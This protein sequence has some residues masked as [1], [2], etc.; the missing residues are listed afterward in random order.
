MIIW[1]TGQPG[2]GKTTLAKEFISI[3]DHQKLIHIDGDDLRDLMDNKDYSYLG[4]VS[5]IKLAQNLALFMESKGFTPVVSLVS[6]YKVQRE[7]FKSKTTVLEVYLHTDEIRG[8]ENYFVDH[9]IEPNENYLD[10][11]TGKLTVEECINEILNVYRK[12][13]NNT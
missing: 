3:L 1:F 7:E 4:R 11:D 13:A 12:M 2:S 10:L 5:N 8:R 9:Y 6:P